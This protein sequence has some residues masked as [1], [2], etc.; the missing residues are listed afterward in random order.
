M[1]PDTPDI[2]RWTLELLKLQVR[3]E[4]PPGYYPGLER[5]RVLDEVRTCEERMALGSEMK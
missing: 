4:D 2:V 1:D 5:A 3:V